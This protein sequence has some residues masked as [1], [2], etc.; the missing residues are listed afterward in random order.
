MS[1]QS[2]SCLLKSKVH[3]VPWGLHMG[4]YWLGLGNSPVVSKQLQ[5]Y[6]EQ[7]FLK[8]LAEGLYWPPGRSGR[9]ASPSVGLPAAPNSND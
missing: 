1:A 7:G 3:H 6:Q 8:N 4:K 5:Y 2:D 9:F